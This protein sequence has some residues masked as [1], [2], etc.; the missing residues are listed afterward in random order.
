MFAFGDKCWT[1]LPP[2]NN[3]EVEGQ[4]CIAEAFVS[5]GQ[6]INLTFKIFIA[7]LL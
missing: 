5:L 6:N 4:K 2:S 1:T 7:V 3:I